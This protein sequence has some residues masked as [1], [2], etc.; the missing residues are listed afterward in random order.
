ML[1]G[2]KTL[3]AFDPITADWVSVPDRDDLKTA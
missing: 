3:S 2:R 1:P